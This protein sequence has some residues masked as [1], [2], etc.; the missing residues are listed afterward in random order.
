MNN[1]EKEKNG[2]IGANRHFLG[3][4]STLS[5][6]DQ[7]GFTDTRERQLVTVMASTHFY[8]QALDL[9][10]ATTG[11]MLLLAAAWGP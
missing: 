5:R 6:P 10:S 2:Q 9:N 7:Q 3:R 1:G 8:L 11:H 4:Y